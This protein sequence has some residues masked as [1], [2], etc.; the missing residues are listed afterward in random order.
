LLERIARSGDTHGRC[1]QLNGQ[2][3]SALSS[4]SA[5]FCKAQ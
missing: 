5:S 4:E 1:L 3:A 2:H